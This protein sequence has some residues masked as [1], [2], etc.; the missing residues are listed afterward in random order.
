[1]SAVAELLFDDW[2][3]IGEVPRGGA[4]AI[5]VL[6]L[7]GLQIPI[8]VF[9]TAAGRAMVSA[10]NDMERLIKIRVKLPGK[11]IYEDPI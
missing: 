7:E 10:A 9:L 4:K 1:M 2:V 6:Q 11:I 3:S 5:H 8:S